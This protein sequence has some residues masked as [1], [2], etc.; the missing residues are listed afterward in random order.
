MAVSITLNEEKCAGCNKCIAE[1]PVD[2]AN[3]A[4]RADDG[5]NKVRTN[6]DLCILCGH[7]IDV[8]DHL[9]R[10]Y[11]DD[12]ERFFADLRSGTKISVVAAPAVRFNFDDYRRVFGFLK[13]AGVNLIYD[14]SLGA[15]ITTWAYLKAIGEKKLK[16]VIAQPCPAIVSFIEKHKPELIEWL[17]PVHSPT[18][19]TA[20][21]LRK[22]VGVQD[23][24]AFLSPCLGKVQEFEDTDELVGYNVTY[25]KLKEY[26]VR[27]GIRFGDYE[28]HDFDD[29]GCGLGLTFSR[30]GGLRENV[31]YHTGGAAWVRQVE[32][33]DHAY[34]YLKDYADRAKNGKELPLLIDILNCA[35]G[36]NL[37]TGT[38]KDISID[39]VDVKMNGL[40]AERLR[41]KTE[42]RDGKEVY[43]LF[44]QFDRELDL[45]DFLRAYQDKSH[46]A[47]KRHV[48]D[49]E[50]EKVFD[51]L[52]K[53]DEPSRNVNCYACGYGNCKHFAAAIANGENHVE[54]CINYNRAQAE[55]EHEAV[56]EKMR[57]LGDMQQMIEDIN[58]LN[59]EKEAKAVELEGHVQEIISAMDEVTSGSKDGASAIAAISGQVEGIHHM[60]TSVR[61]NIHAAETKLAVFEK[62]REDIIHIASQTNMLALNAAIEAAR[63]GE[64]GRGFEVVASEVK[65]LAAQTRELAESTQASEVAIRAGNKQLLEMAHALEKQMSNVTERVSSVSSLIEETTAKCQQISKTAQNIVA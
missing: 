3:V 64:A 34:G 55:H 49:E 47:E 52:Y 27:N 37:G 36:C 57:E 43:P 54:N 65:H 39:D 19:C 13:R 44:E 31:D 6:P 24:I 33:V 50:Y 7:C 62:S 15:D 32:G 61:D 8:C 25:K 60:A 51:S 1:C 63:A 59:Q 12:T 4:Y 14:V 48:S 10:D 11:H 38:G 18:L 42:Q 5:R 22:Y 29:I 21:Y 56:A 16:S 9:A 23:K 41:Q 2:G 53:R 40:K 26:A 28:E 46:H 45:R 58:R 17:A 20:V 30:P 35:H